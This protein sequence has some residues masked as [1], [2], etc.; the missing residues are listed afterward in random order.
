MP[1]VTADNR[2]RCVAFVHPTM[3]AMTTC[4]KYADWLIANVP[5]NYNDRFGAKPVCR[6]CVAKVIINAGDNADNLVFDTVVV[7]KS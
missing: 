4:K 5:N 3:G 6:D 2:P 1:K 7:V